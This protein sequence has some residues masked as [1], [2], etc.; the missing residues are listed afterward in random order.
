MPS[1]CDACGRPLT[2]SDRVR[3]G[4]FRCWRC[5]L[6]L[7]PLANEEVTPRGLPFTIAAA[8]GLLLAAVI[9]LALLVEVVYLT[10]WVIP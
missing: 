7:P 5:A 3:S 9:G 2:L 4:N 6:G 8:I 10:F 1:K